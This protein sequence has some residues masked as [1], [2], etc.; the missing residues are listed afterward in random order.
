MISFRGAVSDFVHGK[1]RSQ[2]EGVFRI[3]RPSGCHSVARFADAQANRLMTRRASSPQLA[4]HTHRLADVQSLALSNSTSESLRAV[5]IYER[6]S[7]Q[8]LLFLPP[9][10]ET[11]L[12]A[13][14]GAVARVR[15]ANTGTG[16]G[17]RLRPLEVA[18]SAARVFWTEG[19]RWRPDSNWLPWTAGVCSTNLFRPM[20]GHAPAVPWKWVCLQTPSPFMRCR[21]TWQPL[22]LGCIKVC[23]VEFDLAEQHLSYLLAVSCGEGSDP[24]W[25]CENW[26]GHGCGNWASY[27]TRSD[28]RLAVFCADRSRS[29]C[30]PSTFAR[31]V[32]TGGRR[33]DVWVENRFKY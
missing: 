10:S 4:S 9:N 26:K 11:V 22:S 12:G 5:W 27:H 14:G 23:S 29:P 33:P 13:Q 16:L 20:L 31:R 1:S 30:S 2:M 7:R 3:K 28:W 24:V 15:Q 6:P 19:G 8:F 17:P 18:G 32:V 21:L 25:D